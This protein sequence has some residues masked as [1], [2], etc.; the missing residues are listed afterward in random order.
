MSFTKNFQVETIEKLPNS[1]V[2]KLIRVTEYQKARVLTCKI[3][4][5]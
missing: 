3:I 1:Y 2:E 4:E 5:Q